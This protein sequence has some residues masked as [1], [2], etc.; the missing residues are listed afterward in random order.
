MAIRVVPFQMDGLN[1]KLASMSWAQAEK[2]VEEGKKLVERGADVSNDEWLARTLQT[3]HASMVKA[4]AESNGGPAS[5]KDEY[6]M[7]TLNAMFTKI[8]EISGLRTTQ[9]EAGAA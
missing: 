1:I 3:V 9:G 4:G 5:L 8:L 6:D 2:F 7:P